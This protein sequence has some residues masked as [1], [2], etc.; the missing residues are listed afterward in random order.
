MEGDSKSP[1]A[2]LSWA[3]RAETLTVPQW[4]PVLFHAGGGLGRQP[5]A[6]NT[7]DYSHETHWVGS[8]I[9]LESEFGIML[10]DSGSC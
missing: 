7:A 10:W 5:C 9:P 1:A 6:Q 2:P 8:T 3:P 4:G